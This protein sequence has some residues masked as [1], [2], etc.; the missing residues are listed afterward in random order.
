MGDRSIPEEEFGTIQKDRTADMKSW[1]AAIEKLSK[2]KKL[3]NG[4][5]PMSN[6]YAGFAAATA[7]MLRKL[8]GLKPAIWEEM[9]QTTLD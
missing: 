3:K 9:K 4:Y 6:H 2:N 1:A 5:M 7:N 8:V